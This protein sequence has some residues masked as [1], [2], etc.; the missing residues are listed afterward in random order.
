MTPNKS[1]L[2]TCAPS[3][4]AAAASASAVAQHPNPHI[5]LGWIPGQR[6]PILGRMNSQEL[7]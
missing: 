6:K 5:I 1:L 4:P 7:A 3:G 2:V